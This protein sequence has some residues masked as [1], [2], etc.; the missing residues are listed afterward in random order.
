MQ[1]RPVRK[2]HKPPKFPQTPR[3]PS[4]ERRGAHQQK[5]F[6]ADHLRDPDGVIDAN[7]L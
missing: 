7:P 5:C 4:L 6:H 2:R 1:I 3:E